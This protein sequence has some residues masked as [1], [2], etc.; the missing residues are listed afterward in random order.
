MPTLLDLF[1]G[2]GGIT[3]GSHRAGFE[4][5]LAVDID[6]I[7]TS[8]FNLN[9]PQTK[10]ILKD[11]KNLTTAELNKLIPDG[12]DGVVGGP[13]CQAFSG[14]G[15]GKE[16]DPRREL[17]DHY[18]RIV[19]CIDP[20]FFLMENVPGL[21]FEKNSHVLNDAIRSLP[22]KWNVLDP[23]ILDAADYGAPTKRK[24]VFVFGFNSE[25]I[26]TPNLA[27]LIKSYE[28]KVTVKDAISDLI[29]TSQ[30]SGTAETW[31]HLK[32]KGISAY[33]SKMRSKSL[34]F[35]GHQLTE[36]RPDT[37][38]RYA[39]I[40][41]GGVDPVGKHKRLSWDGF[42]PTLRA[43]TGN[44]RGSYQSVRPLHPEIN[45]VI[46]PREAAR[47][48]GFPD[49]F[50]FHRTVWHSFRMIGNSV[51]PLIAEALLRN[52]FAYLSSQPKSRHSS[53]PA[54]YRNKTA[55]LEA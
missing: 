31:Q 20:S 55:A 23:V 25:K 30:I 26:G 2:C 28:P 16:D 32:L 33:A 7:L 36:H 52:I 34:Q 13:P 3:L 1:C 37:V 24:R 5:A 45:R 22:P 42:C 29:H 8:S 15:R 44:D 50:Y 14:M 19:S 38:R 49:D 11:I 48:Q 46:T 9:F 51:S 41:Q 39:T 47:L 18:F 6:P 12:V 4:T 53:L 40:P 27:D 17:L 35:T 54:T 10:L 21:M 43:G